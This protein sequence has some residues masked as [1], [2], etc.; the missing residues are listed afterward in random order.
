MGTAKSKIKHFRIQS[1]VMTV[2]KEMQFSTKSFYILNFVFVQQSKCIVVTRGCEIEEKLIDTKY[3]WYTEIWHMT[4]CRY[5]VI[6]ELES[7]QVNCL[8]QKG[9]SNKNEWMFFVGFQTCM[10]HSH[11][12]FWVKDDIQYNC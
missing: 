2:E 5:V 8:F 12:T 7:F 10:F 9:I 1:S 11:K 3:F 6:C 4:I